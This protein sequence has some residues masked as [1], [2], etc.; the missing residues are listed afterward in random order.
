MP[1]LSFDGP[2]VAFAKQEGEVALDKDGKRVKDDH[3]NE[4][5]DDLEKD[6]VVKDLRS[7][8]TGGDNLDDTDEIILEGEIGNARDGDGLR[9]T[10]GA[11]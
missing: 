2:F 1:S 5:N 3:D 9:Y 10:A 6:A 8:Q 11:A 4:G 7:Q